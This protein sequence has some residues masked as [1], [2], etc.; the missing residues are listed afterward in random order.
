M[1]YLAYGSN[2]NRRQ[3]GWRCP[4]AEPIASVQ[5]RGW[6]LVMRGVADIE[7]HA[8]GATPAALW[9]ITRLCREALDAYEGYP[10]FYIR[11]RVTV[12]LENGSEAQPM[13]YLMTPGNRRL[14]EP[15][16]ERY[17]AGVAEGY[18]DFGFA[19]LRPLERAQDRATR[20]ARKRRRQHRGMPEWVNA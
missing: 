13:V 20:L 6:R 5:L 16:S 14:I 8:R 2:M 1:L 3:M 12:V 18:A 10:H 17:L 4:A 15:A 7:P 11:Q 9:E 19:D